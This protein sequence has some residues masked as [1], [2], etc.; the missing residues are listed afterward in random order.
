MSGAELRTCVKNGLIIKIGRSNGQWQI[1]PISSQA[2][3]CLALCYIQIFTER[4][5]H[6]SEK[7]GKYFQVTLLPSINNGHLR[8]N[9]HLILSKKFFSSGTKF[10]LRGHRKPIWK[11]FPDRFEGATDFWV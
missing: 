4:V 10:N 6:D 5:I 9:V 3:D 8:P 1:L 11:I 7:C 2:F